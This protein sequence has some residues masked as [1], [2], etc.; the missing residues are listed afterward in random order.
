LL[1]HVGELPRPRLVPGAA[2]LVAG[3][4]VP[5]G[6]V[7]SATRDWARTCLGDLLDRFTVVVTRAEVSR[8]KP[9]PEPYSLA[10]RKLGVGAEDCCAVEDAPAGVA[11]AVAAGIGLVIAVS[12]TF[13]PHQLEAAH[14]VVPGLP[15]VQLLIA[16]QGVPRARDT[17]HT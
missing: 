8:G 10:C 14:H 11:S 3:A 7:T 9:D 2:E 15:D 6:L 17:E 5:L 4:G 1:A 12:T 16:R 13:T